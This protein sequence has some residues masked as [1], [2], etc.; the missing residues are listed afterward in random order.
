M[1]RQYFAHRFCGR[2]NPLRVGT[3]AAGAIYYIQPDSW[4]RDRFRGRPDC[5]EP[6]MVE[7]FFNGTLAAA[8]RDQV[9]GNWR[10]LY[11]KGRSDMALIRSLRTA[12]TK[13]IAVG[14]LR[15]HDDEGLC[16]GIQGYPTLPDR[17][18][19]EGYFRGRQA[20]RNPARKAAA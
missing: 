4:W 20:Q 7:A 12:R 19:V 3:I 17:S 6:W 13:Q 18:L 9:T 2:D 14:V 5:R 16:P 8:C 15:L 1:F 11:I 10:S